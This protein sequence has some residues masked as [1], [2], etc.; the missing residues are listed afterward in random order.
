MIHWQEST[1]EI[2]EM[3]PSAAS[4][5]L[6]T[7]RY[8]DQRS[9]D[10]GWVRQYALAMEQERFRP[11]SL[12]SY[13]LHAGQR[14]LVNGQHTLEAIVLS[15]ETY[16]VR[17]EVFPVDT[18]EDIALL[19]GTFDQHRRRSNSQIYRAYRL[20]EQANLGKTH[21]VWIGA[22]M[23]MVMSGFTP[24]PTQAR[25]F[26]V[27]MR[28]QWIKAQCITSWANEARIY[29]EVIHNCPSEI[30][31]PLRRAAVLAVALVTLR[32]T[33]TD[34]EDFWMQ[35]AMGSG[36]TRG[37]ARLTLHHFLREKSAKEYDAHI[38]ARFVASAWNAA[39]DKRSLKKLVVQETSGD[40]PIRIAGTPHDGM[41]VMRYL[42]QDGK[43]LEQPEEYQT[44]MADQPRSTYAA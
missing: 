8:E 30:S 22:S 41:R 42:T 28:D 39:Y 16:P 17:E 26:G 36:L 5:I 19:Y 32:H 7:A 10:W 35:V 9:I 40:K 6:Q 3:S 12:I 21:I 11:C 31:Q 23:P 34:A 38:Y 27:F 44:G 24:W 13:A 20:D 4:H 25:G 2:I 43:V 29:F 18:P 14:I 33:G 37:D 1:T 15:D